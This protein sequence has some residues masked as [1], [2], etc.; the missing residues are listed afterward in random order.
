MR[1]TRSIAPVHLALLLPLTACAPEPRPETLADLGGYDGDV[2]IRIAYGEQQR[3]FEGRLAF[4]R[5]AGRLSF[6]GK[7]DG[8][9]IAIFREGDEAPTAEGPTGSRVPLG[10]E[11][12]GAFALLIALIQAAPDRDATVEPANGGYRVTSGGQVIEVDWSQR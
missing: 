8:R 3:I 2:V 9:A 4:D 5:A 7:V 10:P 11:D 12:E 6:V 1:R